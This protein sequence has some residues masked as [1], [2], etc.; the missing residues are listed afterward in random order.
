MNA[1]RAARIV[2]ELLA[3]AIFFIID[4]KD[5]DEPASD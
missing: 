5:A 2:E 3:F 1:E 4:R